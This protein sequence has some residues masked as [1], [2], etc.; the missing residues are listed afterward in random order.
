MTETTDTRR[1][2]DQVAGRYAAEIGDELTGKPLDRALLAALAEFGAGGPVLDVGC[3]PGQAAAELAGRGARPVGVDLSPAMC[4][5]AHRATALPCCAA[6]MTALPVR[7]AAVTAIVCLY[8][9]IHLDPPRRAAAY[10][11]FARVLRPGGS[12]LIAFHTGDEQTPPGQARTLTDW[13]GHP[14]ALTFRFLDPAA[15]V[16][17]L[18]RAGLALTARLDRRPD[19]AREHASERCYLLVRRA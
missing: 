11:E 9:V 13:W 17:A 12:A 18:A 19:P 15:E 2:Y 10:A 5:L 14:V 16:A 1:S 6:D 8:A 3:G 7:S 4:A